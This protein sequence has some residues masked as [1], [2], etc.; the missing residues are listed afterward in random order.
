M[1]RGFIKPITA[2]NG[3]PYGS[4][5]L[6]IT[7][8]TIK[9]DILTKASSSFTV[10]DIPEQAEVGNVF[11]CYDETGKTVYV[12]IITNI[13]DKTIQTD[14][15][16]SIFNDN[17]KYRNPNVSTIEGK[18]ANIISGFASD[19]DSLLATIFSQF[20]VT[21]TSSTTLDLPSQS[22]NYV[23]NL[24]DFL[25][26]I[27]ES[28]HILVDINVSYGAVSPTIRIGVSSRTTHLLSDNNNV[29][30]D[31]NVITE[32]YETNKLILYSSDGTYRG[33]WYGTPTG[34]TTNSA[35][36]R[37]PKIR[38]NIVFSN[39]DYNTIV[40]DNLSADMYNHK[41][42]MNLVLNNKLYDFDEFAL[43]GSFT[44]VYENKTYDS[45]L[46]GYE[47]KANA[48]GK[49]DMVKLVFGIVRVS[50]VD[51]LNKL[52]RG[53]QNLNSEQIRSEITST[54]VTNALGYTPQQQL[55]Y[56]PASMAYGECSTAAA[57]ARK[58]VTTYTPADWKLQVG[59]VIGIKFT[60]TNTG[61]NPTLQIGSN[62]AKSIVYNTGVISTSNLSYAGYAN[63]TLYY[64]YDGTYFRFL[65]WS[66]DSNSTYSVIAEADIKDSSHT[67]GRTI[68][69]QRFSQGFDYYYD[70]KMPLT[71]GNMTNT[72]T[73]NY[74][75]N[76]V[77]GTHYYY[78]KI[79]RI[80]TV[81][82]NVLCNTAIKWSSSTPTFCSG[83][84]ATYGS[85]EV[86]GSLHTADKNGD[87]LAI[88]IQGDGTVKAS[89]GTDG[90]YYYG[91][92][93]YISAS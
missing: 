25:F 8:L 41:I 42:E 68:T 7:D 26:N 39:D 77:A 66:V 21:I 52:V 28:Y 24:M 31:F 93:S 15:I 20:T 57:T 19:S 92:V 30:R 35:A 36:D 89:G 27:Y 37:L 13:E 88:A 53:Q 83:L 87:G 76:G 17:W 18:I 11:G 47:L 44:I 85:K 40:Q 48:N 84:P 90:V 73:T 65:S 22:E 5:D 69:G 70:L 72:T 29:L 46:T 54:N 79:G 59:S 32:T 14:Q 50:L 75:L 16:I 62:A 78:V 58:V 60:K 56:T 34:I 4:R 67:T 43:G 49:S 74:Q 51:K 80:V 2:L 1:Y 10:L 55:G 86:Y 71:T 6:R 81:S 9:R 12:G 45:I 82:F 91:S 63:R 23:T 33:T 3:L 38:T 61:Q 64:M